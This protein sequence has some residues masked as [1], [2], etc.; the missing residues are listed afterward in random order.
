MT[1]RNVWETFYNHN[2]STYM[3][4]GPVQF[5][6]QEVDFLINELGFTPGDS[7]LDVGCGTGRHSVE[8]ARR[9]FQVT[10][11]DISS[12]MLQEASKAAEQAG[13]DVEFIQCDATKFLT[14][15]QYDAAICLCEGAFGLFNVDDNGSATL[16]W[17]E[18]LSLCRVD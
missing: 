18:K 7:V 11:I 9:G 12:G 5:T 15:K 14:N 4:G 1:S 13:V 16:I 3:Q 10:G 2:A 17:T 8:L 6:V